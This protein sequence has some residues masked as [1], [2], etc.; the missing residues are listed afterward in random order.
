MQLNKYINLHRLNNRI[1]RFA[2]CLGMYGLKDS[3]L[4]KFMFFESD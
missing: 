1:L 4:K 2:E 3:E